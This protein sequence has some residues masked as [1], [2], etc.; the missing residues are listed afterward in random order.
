MQNPS[1]SILIRNLDHVKDVIES[2]K[3]KTP[4]HGDVV[5]FT[6]GNYWYIRTLIN[7]LL[8][9]AQI[10]E[11]NI[12]I[13]VFCSDIEGHNECKELGFKHYGIVDIPLLDVDKLLSGTDASTRQYTRLS[14]V[15]I[16]ITQYIL[17]LGYTP[18]YLDPDMAFKKAS[19]DDLLSY[20]NN[21]DFICAGTHSYINSNILIAKPCPSNLELFN[22]NVGDFIKVLND[23]NKYGDEDFLRPRLINRKFAC[24]DRQEYPPGCDAEKNLET[25]RIIHA[26]CVSGL[27]NKIELLKRCH[28]WYDKI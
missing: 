6:N 25:A 12:N 11:P 4:L 10:H 5:I 21:N 3:Y 15:K 27:D 28:V 19:I 17:S 16:A 1:D 2:V 13:A 23:P 18:L 14:F 22:L 8:K 26:N 20:L 7:N 24:L 9:S